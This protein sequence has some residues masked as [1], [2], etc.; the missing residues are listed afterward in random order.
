MV[1]FIPVIFFSFVHGGVWADGAG[2]SFSLLVPCVSGGC[3]LL[4]LVL[5]RICELDVSQFL[6]ILTSILVR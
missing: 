3:G 6:L 4:G 5:L 1:S 2:K